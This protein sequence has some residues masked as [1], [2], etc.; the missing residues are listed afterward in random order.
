MQL[1]NVIV[2]LVFAILVLGAWL[3]VQDLGKGGAVMPNAWP[4]LV[5]DDVQRLELAIK[6]GEGITLRRKAD[7]IEEWEIQ[8]DTLWVPAQSMRIDELL[9]AGATVRVSD[10]E[11][12][13]TT[14]RVMGV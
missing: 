11:A 9:N 14:R 2:M 4:K 6:G 5:K 10:P 8:R 7:S 3:A 1:R 12:I 13:E